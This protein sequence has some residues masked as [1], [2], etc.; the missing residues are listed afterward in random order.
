MSSV[1]RALLHFQCRAVPEKTQNPKRRRRGEEQAWLS[2][3]TLKAAKEK[4]IAAASEDI[5]ATQ[6]MGNIHPT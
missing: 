3:D 6:R 4:E 5:D 1:L 2:F